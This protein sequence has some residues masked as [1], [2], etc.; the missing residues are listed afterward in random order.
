MAAATATVALDQPRPEY[1]EDH[2]AGKRRLKMV[3][4]TITVVGDYATGGVSVSTGISKY[5]KNLKRVLISGSTLASAY[6]YTNSKIL[7]YGDVGTAALG[8][9]AEPNGVTLSSTAFDFIAVGY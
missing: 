3:T 4:G 1:I 7:L 9:L 6:D 8:V 5:F 2:G